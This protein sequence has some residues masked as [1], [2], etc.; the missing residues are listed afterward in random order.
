[1]RKKH[2]SPTPFG[3]NQEI[4]TT[5]SSQIQEER[6]QFCKEV[7]TADLLFYNC[8]KINASFANNKKKS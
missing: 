4:N 1:M 3:A 2:I 7:R 5:K 6:V 8:I